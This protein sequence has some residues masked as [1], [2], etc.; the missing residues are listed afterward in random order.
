MS[1]WDDRF[2]A[3]AQEVATWSKD[4]DVKVGAVAVSPDRRRFSVG[5]NGFPRGIADED[6]RLNDK[7]LKNLLTV[8]AEQNVVY[9][10]GDLTGWTLY[11]TRAPCVECAL[12]IIQAGFA[13]V[14]CFRPQT[15]DESSWWRDQLTASNLLTEAR[16][17]VQWRAV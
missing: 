17:E 13:R 5:Y 15:P 14:V 16:I 2:Y 6:G 11:A 9:N 8:H 3:M 7:E 1:K 4:P 12:A 10:G